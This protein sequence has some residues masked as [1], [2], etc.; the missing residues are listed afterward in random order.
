MSQEVWTVRKILDWTCGYLERKGDEHPRL[1]AEWLL[2]NACGLSRIEIY[3]NFDRPLAE[4]EL[5]LMRDAVRR[6]G[7]GEP[8]QYVT[9]DMPFRHIIVRCERGVLIPRPETEILV[10]AALEG[11]DA[12]QERGCVF[13]D[14][15]IRDAY[16][17]D[18]YS[19]VLPS[20][21][22]N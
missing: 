1:S 16:D 13:D 15:E 6:R 18:Y 4:N 12:A 8:L 9:G 14:G 21:I 22:G 19:C 20:R 11:V 17:V 2:C 3:M 7:A 5:A 10:D